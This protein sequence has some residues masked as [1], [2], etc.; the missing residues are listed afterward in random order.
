MAPPIRLQ[1]MVFET[2]GKRLIGEKA[3]NN[4]TKKS[5]KL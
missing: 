4:E 2:F 5:I 1:R 3:G